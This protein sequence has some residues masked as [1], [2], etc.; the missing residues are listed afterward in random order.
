MQ[1]EGRYHEQS[2]G[3]GQPIIKKIETGKS[4]KL[5]G[6]GIVHSNQMGKQ[7][8]P[9]TKVRESEKK[10]KGGNI[11]LNWLVPGGVV[12]RSSRER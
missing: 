10:K 1:E 12:I 11:Y 5:G 4:P 7:H 2:T 8:L 9:G 6:E 3:L